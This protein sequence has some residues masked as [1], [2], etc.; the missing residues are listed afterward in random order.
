[1]N[2]NLNLW[3]TRLLWLAPIVFFVLAIFLLMPKLSPG[4]N[5]WHKIIPIIFLVSTTALAW[6][7]SETHYQK[8]KKKI[9]K[10]LS[11][12]FIPL[13][14]AYVILIEASVSLNDG[15]LEYLKTGVLTYTIIFLAIFFIMWLIFVKLPIGKWTFLAASLLGVLFELNQND[16]IGFSI[17]SALLWIWFLHVTWFLTSIFIRPKKL[18]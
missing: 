15:M 2:K 9:N 1:M 11:L 6:Y 7:I 5:I 10:P 16:S 8:I 12:I 14:F 18:L 3:L 4:A 17:L 13:S